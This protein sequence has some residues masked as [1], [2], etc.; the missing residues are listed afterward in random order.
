[1]AKPPDPAVPRL[2]DMSEGEA[3]ALVRRL[4]DELSGRGTHQAFAELLGLVAYA[5]E[6]VGNAARTLAASSS[7]SE[8][9]QVS[10]TSKQAAW[11]RWRL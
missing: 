1:M 4:L 9:G 2:T 8:V 7:W 6:S 11:E 5:G 3:A 10:G